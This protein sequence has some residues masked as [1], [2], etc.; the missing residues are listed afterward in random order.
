MKETCCA[1]IDAAQLV[2]VH[3]VCASWDYDRVADT[4]EIEV[5]PA[6][7]T[8]QERLLLRWTFNSPGREICKCIYVVVCVPGS[9]TKQG[10]F[11]FPESQSVESVNAFSHHIRWLNTLAYS[12]IQAKASVWKNWCHTCWRVPFNSS[13]IVYIYITLTLPMSLHLC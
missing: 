11:K 13:H 3:D 2:R 10:S 8:L 12:H 5:T 1:L 9:G 7:E 4:C 6:S